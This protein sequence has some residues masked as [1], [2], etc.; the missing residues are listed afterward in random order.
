MTEAEKRRLEEVLE[1][2]TKP[3][4][5]W[6]MARGLTMSGSPTVAAAAEKRRARALEEVAAIL[7]RHSE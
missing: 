6:R 5:V 2:L 4:F 7:N 3:L 1:R